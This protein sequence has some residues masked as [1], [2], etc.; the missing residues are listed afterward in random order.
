M[1]L[2]GAIREQLLANEGKTFEEED[3]VYHFHTILQKVELLSKKLTYPCY[4]ILCSS[5]LQAAISILACIA[6]DTIAVPLSKRYGDAHCQRIIHQ[7]G[8]RYLITDEGSDGEFVIKQVSEIPFEVPDGEKPILIMYT[9][10]TT[11][12]PK[13]AMISQKNLLC[14]LNDIDIYFQIL[15]TDRILI[16]R[17]L[18][19]CAVLT[20]EFLISV[21]KGLDIVFYSGPFNPFALCSVVKTK[22]ITV[23]GGTPTLFYHMASMEKRLQFCKSL[24]II[25]TSGECMTSAVADRIIETFAGANIYNVYGLTEAS[26]RVAYLPPSLFASRCTS[27]GYPL[28]SL[29]A[30]IILNTGEEAPPGIDGELIVKGASVML[31]YYRDAGMTAEKIREGWLYTG[32]VATISKDGLITIKCRKDNLIIKSGINIYPQEIENEIKHC[33]GIRE[34]YVYARNDSKGRMLICLLVEA[35]GITTDQIAE[36]CRAHLPLYEV[37][38]MIRIVESISRNGSGKINRNSEHL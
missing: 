35:E 7:A 17:P 21:L 15:Q 30:K 8:L 38:D 33:E 19:H 32:D 11:G 23:M 37:P 9:S 26:P 24:R 14:N 2:W 6:A 36:Y 34:A 5:E 28:H 22:Q 3:K 18:Y 29:Q 10:G 1:E 12:H 16:S 27:V 25:V 20:G 4:G 13:G 31:G